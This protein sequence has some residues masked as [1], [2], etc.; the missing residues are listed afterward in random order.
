MGSIF[1]VIAMLVLDFGSSEK[2]KLKEAE[3]YLVQIPAQIAD[4]TSEEVSADDSTK[5]RS[6]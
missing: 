3:Q 6:C 4:I 2:K 5:I 1:I